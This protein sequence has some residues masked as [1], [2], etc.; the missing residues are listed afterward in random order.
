VN[1]AF[2][3]DLV[4]GFGRSD[5]E[6]RIFLCFAGMA[7]TEGN[8]Q[9]FSPF[10]LKLLFKLCKEENLK[11]DPGLTGSFFP[12]HIM[13]FPLNECRVMWTSDDNIFF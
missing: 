4:L 13:V 5:K 3:R 12:C 11:I 6:G 10:R 9:N 7:N 1:P 2:C 8:F